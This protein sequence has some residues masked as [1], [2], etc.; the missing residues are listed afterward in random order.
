MN[1]TQSKA[2]H[3]NLKN[4]IA[5]ESHLSNDQRK[6]REIQTRAAR[7]LHGRALYL[8]LEFTCWNVKPPQDMKPEII[9]IGLAEMDL[10]SLRITREATCFVRPRRWEISLKCTQLTG[11][12]SEN[13]RGAKPLEEALQ[14]LLKNFGSTTDMPCCTWGDDLSVL[15]RSC[16]SLGLANPLKHHIDLS[17]LFQNAFVMKEQVSLTSAIRMMGLDF[18]GMPHTALADARNAAL[19]H[20]TLLRRMR[21][22]PDLPPLPVVE[23]EKV[24]IGVFAEKLKACLQGVT[25][26]RSPPAGA[27]NK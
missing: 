17:R 23:P 5:D 25:L 12:T 7:N 27:P 21:G 22:L 2:G 26:G 10:E 13:I 9:E 15:N 18:D 11:I 19:L 3:H 6:S 1:T 20:A 4:V 14:T 24:I 16:A 8:D